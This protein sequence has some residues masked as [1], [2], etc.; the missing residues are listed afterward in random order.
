MDV[1]SGTSTIDRFNIGASR[2][3]DPSPEPARMTC[4]AGGTGRLTDFCLSITLCLAVTNDK[5]LLTGMR[6]LHSLLALLKK[7]FIWMDWNQGFSFVRNDG[8]R[9]QTGERAE[10]PAT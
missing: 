10:R 4:R 3:R 9:E 2:E 8:T 5:K 7:L 1:D 6:L